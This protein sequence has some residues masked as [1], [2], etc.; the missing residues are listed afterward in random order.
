M[1]KELFLVF[2]NKVGKDYMG[3]Y[4]YDFIFS[5]TTDDID[6]EEWDTVPASSRPQPPNEAFIQAA[7]RLE[8]EIN[9][10]VVQ[11]SD[12]FAVWD[13]VDGVIALGWENVSDY[14]TYPE[15][16]LIFGFGE[17]KSEVEG[18]LYEKDLILDYKN[19]KNGKQ[20]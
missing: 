20:K 1:E 11:D 5:E 6:G 14:E 12:T 7:G 4:I 13:A 17:P 10:D 19:K 8:T 18:K 15:L 3:N 2:I 9:F 16:R